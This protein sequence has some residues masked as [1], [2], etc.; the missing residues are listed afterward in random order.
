MAKP[1]FDH[2]Y[3]SGHHAPVRFEAKSGTE[4]YYH[5]GAGAAAGELVFAPRIGSCGEEDGYAMTI[6]H[7]AN[8]PTSELA[9][10]AAG[11]IAAGPIATVSIPYRVP[12]GFHCNFYAA[13]S[14]LYPLSPKETHV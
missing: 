8:S 7:R 5:F 3:H 11:D 13:D 9:I 4:D 6:V 1:F 10:F 2:P 14:A 12:A